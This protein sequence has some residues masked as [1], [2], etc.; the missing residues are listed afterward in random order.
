MIKK[1]TLNAFKDCAGQP[2]FAGLRTDRVIK[3]R[4]AVAK[5]YS[6]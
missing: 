3:Y 1:M 4:A 5:I 2:T 6:T